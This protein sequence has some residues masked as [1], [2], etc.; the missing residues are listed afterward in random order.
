MADPDPTSPGD[1]PGGGPWG[2][3][4]PGPGHDKYMHGAQAAG[5]RNMHV[6]FLGPGL[7]RSPPA[8]PGGS[9][10]RPPQGIIFATRGQESVSALV[11]FMTSQFHPVHERPREAKTSPTPCRPPPP[12]RNFGKSIWRLRRRPPNQQLQRWRL[13]VVQPLICQK[14]GSVAWH[15]R[16]NLQR[17][18][19]TACR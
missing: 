15:L 16:I 4:W 17:S 9:P 6:L 5:D 11:P 1:P 19:T 14:P 8:S 12:Y 3:S 10:S 13:D 2:T 7:A 18:L